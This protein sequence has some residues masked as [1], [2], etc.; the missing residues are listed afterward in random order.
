L[1]IGNLV[2]RG[3][4]FYHDRM[5]KIVAELEEKG[6]VVSTMIALDAKVCRLVPG[7]FATRSVPWQG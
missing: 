6:D 2:E 5:P 4:S 3:E 7:L 1:K